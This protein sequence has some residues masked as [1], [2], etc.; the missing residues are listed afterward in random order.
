M[1]EQISPDLCTGSGYI[2]HWL[3]VSMVI[4]PCSELEG[5]CLI[6][7]VYITEI[8]DWRKDLAETVDCT[9]GWVGQETSRVRGS[10]RWGSELEQIVPHTPPSAHE[11][12]AESSSSTELGSTPPPGDGMGLLPSRAEQGE[13]APV[14]EPV[15]RPHLMVISWSVPHPRSNRLFCF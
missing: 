3:F 5:V 9:G 14:K 2:S 13:H 11:H 4:L 12:S 15:A 7:T 6:S 1:I 8:W 10:Q